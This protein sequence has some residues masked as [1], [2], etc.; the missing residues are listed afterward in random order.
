M[1]DCRLPTRAQGETLDTAK[2]RL[3]VTAPV[4]DPTRAAYIVRLR[5]EAKPARATRMVT[6]IIA[7]CGSVGTAVVPI[8]S[9]KLVLVPQRDVGSVTVTV[10]VTT[11]E[12]PSAPWTISHPGAPDAFS[13]HHRTLRHGASVSELVAETS[14]PSV[15]I[16][17]PIVK[18]AATDP[19]TGRGGSTPIGN[20]P[21]RG[22]DG[23]RHAGH[24][25]R[26]WNTRWR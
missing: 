4:P 18:P 6:A 2:S 13:N 1:R 16:G 10:T 19:P 15:M 21:N 12:R 9:C 17:P 8:V 22:R 25:H 11:P 14:S 26:R 20:G 5:I 23:S 7:R 24:L 3:R